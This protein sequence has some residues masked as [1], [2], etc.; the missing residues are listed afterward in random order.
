MGECKTNLIKSD[1]FVLFISG[2]RHGSNSVNNVHHNAGKKRRFA[3]DSGQEGLPIIHLVSL[4]AKHK[5]PLTATMA[6]CMLDQVTN[7]QQEDPPRNAS[8]GVQPCFLVKRRAKMSLVLSARSFKVSSWCVRRYA[9]GV[10]QQER[11]EAR[12]YL[13]E[14]TC[15]RL[16]AS[17]KIEQN[18][19]SSTGVQSD[20]AET[21]SY[22]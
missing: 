16:I 18:W 20:K 8:Q 11:R 15:Q 6:S 1:L 21:L 19:Q 14:A 17:G 12:K 9:V 7:S 4:R 5:A 22:M 2:H 10:R 3:Q 13:H